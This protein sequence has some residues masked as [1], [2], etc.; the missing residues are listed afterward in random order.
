MRPELD[1]EKKK[2]E[3]LIVQDQLVFHLIPVRA[4]E[5]AL[6]YHDKHES[7]NPLD[8][9]L[10]PRTHKALPLKKIHNILSVLPT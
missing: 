2:M 5:P 8:I 9:Y 10:F 1:R 3:C 6:H 7:E 4:I